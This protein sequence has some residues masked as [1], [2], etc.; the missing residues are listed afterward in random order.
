MS[1]KC[2]GRSAVLVAAFLLAAAS[3]SAA[4]PPAATA[5]DPFATYRDYLGA[6][7]SGAAPSPEALARYLTDEGVRQ[8]RAWPAESRDMVGGFFYFGYGLYDARLG[9]QTITGERATLDVVLV[10]RDPNPAGSRDREVPGKVEMV[11]TARG[12][13]VASE[14]LTPPQS[15]DWLIESIR[16]AGWTSSDGGAWTGLRG[17]GVFPEAFASA[18]VGTAAAKARDLATGDS[19][20]IAEVRAVISGEAAYQS[21]NDGY[22]DR[23]DCLSRPSG[24]IPQWSG[25][26]FLDPA[27]ASTAVRNGYRTRFDAGSPAAHKT[28]AMSPSS[29][30]SYAVWKIPEPGR[31]G[32]VVCG[33]SSGTVCAM[34]DRS[35]PATKGGCPASCVPIP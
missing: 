11:R 5:K 17:A 31:A 16:A 22:Y 26:V 15:E 30:E 12:W 14:V 34:P 25:P 3:G 19:H 4:A 35:A 29:V 6:V 1:I 7:R 20:A 28:P 27:I 2:R 21:S 9:R 18:A 23:L 33:D 32:R 10:Y 8:W 24:C 13:T